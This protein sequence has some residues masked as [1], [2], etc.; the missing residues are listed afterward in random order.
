LK[1]IL[2]YESFIEK[3][4]NVTNKGKQLAEGLLPLYASPELAGLVAA[5]MTDGHVDW[6]TNNGNSRTKRITLYSSKREE[7][8]WFLRLVKKI[9]GVSGKIEAYV[10]NH[11]NWI[12]QPY[13]ANVF[14]A[15][16][17]R[18]LILAGAPAGN[19]T[20]KEFLI[21][22]WIMGGNLEIKREFLRTFF[23]FEGGKPFVKRSKGH[24]YQMSLFMNKSPDLL[25]N[26]FNFFNQIVTLLDFFG[27]SCSR[28]ANRIS[29]N[30]TYYTGKNTIYFTITNHK[31]IVN[32]YHNIGFLNSVKQARLESCVLD[33]AKFHR[34]KS[35]AICRLIK[36]AKRTIGTDRELTDYLNK[37]TAVKYSYRQIEH[38]RKKEI[39]VPLEIVSAL[40]VLLEDNSVL[41]ELPDYAVPLLT[42]SSVRA[43]PV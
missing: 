39:A 27:V 41:K 8:E 5:L 38:F 2:A 28:I 32:F 25:D 4:P 40:I 24:A 16:V 13:K 12:K 35:D 31:S 20:E 18:I 6:Y 19:K 26:A 36:H 10:P 37:F 7:C 11:N 23:T 15:V 17:A 33:I 3:F 42:C 43:S 22:E 30:V 1:P 21:P 14:N 29:K 34:L 9:F